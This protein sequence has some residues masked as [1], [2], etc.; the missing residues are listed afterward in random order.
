[1]KYDIIFYIELFYY[2]DKYLN[3]KILIIIF[4]CLNKLNWRNIYN[5][6]DLLFCINYNWF[7]SI[8]AKLFFLLDLIR[9]SNQ[10]VCSIIYWEKKSTFLVISIDFSLLSTIRMMFV[11]FLHST[12]RL[13]LLNI[14]NI[15]NYCYCFYL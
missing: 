6:S 11:A 7:V 1:M 10:I 8:C 4:F 5:K 15:Y 2:V 3:K 14:R 13:R 9:W 12:S